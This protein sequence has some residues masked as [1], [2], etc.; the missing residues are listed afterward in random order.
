MTQ[1]PL[2]RQVQR[3]E[4]AV[5][6]DALPAHAARRRTHP[7]RH[8]SS[9]KRPGGSSPPRT[10]PRCGPAASRP[11]RRG[12]SASASPPSRPSRS[13]AGGSRSAAAETARRRPRAQRDGHARAARRPARGGDRSRPG[14]P[15]PA[16]GPARLAARGSGLA[17]PRRP[18]R[19]RPDPARPG[20]HNGG[21]GRARRGDLL[22]LRGLVL[23][24]TRRR[25]VPAGALE[26]R[27]TCSTSARSTRSCRWSTPG[28]ASRS[29][30][31]RPARSTSRTW[32]SSTSRTCRSDTVELHSRLASPPRQP[33]PRRPPAQRLISP[34]AGAIESRSTNSVGR[35]SLVFRLAAVDLDP[36]AA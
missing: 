9:S 27:G 36:A 21:R 18:A 12:P 31:P 10:P 7:G 16:L 23:L 30:P 26:P 17:H 13:S 35:R 33:G 14:A 5:G 2:S 11:G 29:C 8:A 28:S 4:R 15:G 25:R 20:A 34:T 24:R 32:S 6:F 3:L 19:P 1:P 22:A